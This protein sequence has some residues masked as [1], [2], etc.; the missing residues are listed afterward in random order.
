MFGILQSNL[1]T[2]S[3]KLTSIV[4]TGNVPKRERRELVKDES[5]AQSTF[6]DISRD[7]LKRLKRLVIV[8]DR[9]MF[10]GSKHSNRSSLS[11][12]DKRSKLQD[13]N[14]LQD[15]RRENKYENSL[16]TENHVDKN[17]DQE[18]EKSHYPAVDINSY[19]GK[20]ESYDVED[21]YRADRQKMEE[22]MD[23][24]YKLLLK[25]TNE[26]NDNGLVNQAMPR[27]MG[28]DDW[29]PFNPFQYPQNINIE[30]L[31][32]T[33]AK[34]GVLPGNPINEWKYT[35]I[36]NPSSKCENS[37][38]GVFLLFI[39]KTKPENFAKRRTLRKTWADEKRFPNIRTVFSIGIP[40]DSSTIKKI[41][42]EFLK[43]K[44]V[45]LMDYMDTYHN[46]TLKTTSGIN[47]AVAR[48]A[49]AEFVVSVDDDMYVATDFLFQHLKDMP[50]AE[51]ERLYHGHLY[52]DTSPVR[53][54][55]K[56]EWHSKWIVTK[57]EYPFDTYPDYI[58]GG[59][60]I[61]SMRT[62][63]EMSLAI[64]YTKPINMEDVYLGI[65]ASRLGIV[66]TNTDL[67]NC[68]LTYSNVEKF[69][70][71]I[72]SHYYTSTHMLEK[73]WEC[74]LSIVEEDVEK[75]VF[76]IYIKTKLE[77]LKYKVDELLNWIDLSDDAL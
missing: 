14:Y 27:D 47:W 36:I 25:L 66:A 15:D 21:E 40:R 12:S 62:V 48:C 71:L 57:E 7:N 11:P 46:L 28:E 31:I 17:G 63:L 30:Q 68:L 16:K 26:D 54:G 2:D 41:K 77:Q 13:E 19:K 73:A 9:K 52:H 33:F 60:I 8:E 64:P 45:L 4:Y 22:L 44:D 37:K 55:K 51:A 72:A 65:V 50:Q 3:E 53:H 76:C 59:F 32:K 69:K 38:N 20:L 42:L 43:Y 61:M 29:F 56:D 18:G 58:F 5:D 24:P 49:V 35:P 67:V 74:H 34:N 1:K 23:E 6:K 10:T 70:T 75:S 39:V